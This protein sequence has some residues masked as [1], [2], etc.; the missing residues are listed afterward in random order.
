M[1]K[2]QGALEKLVISRREPWTIKTVNL[3]GLP[4]NGVKPVGSKLYIFSCRAPA[5]TL[6]SASSDNCM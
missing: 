2:N 5:A 3:H 6:P 1:L 4:S